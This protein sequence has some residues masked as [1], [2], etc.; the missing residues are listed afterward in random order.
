MFGRC[1]FVGLVLG[2]T[3][4]CEGEPGPTPLACAS[5]APILELAT[6]DVGFGEL[7]EGAAIECGI[8][9]QGGAPY[10]AFTIRAAGIDQTE[11]GMSVEL[12]AYDADTGEEL[13]TADYQQRMIC[14]NAGKSAGYWVSSEVHLRYNGWTLEELEGRS[15]EFVTRVI[16]L[17]G[18]EVSRE[19]V[20]SLD[21]DF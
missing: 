20:G 16:G 6:R 2:L 7:E 10:S 4:A 3:V 19:L 18:L 17:D 14:A 11:T 21:L 12:T 9:P 13:G 15:A 8:P 5:G 1:L